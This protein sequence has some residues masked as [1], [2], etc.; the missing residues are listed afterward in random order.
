ML[1]RVKIGEIMLRN[2]KGII[3][4]GRH[5]STPLLGMSYLGRLNIINEGQIMKLEQKY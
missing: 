1:E 4:E 3:I 5:P 2:V